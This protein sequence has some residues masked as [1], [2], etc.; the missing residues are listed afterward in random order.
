MVMEM[1]HVRRAGVKR[2][3]GAKPITAPPGLG[4]QTDG[5]TALE[6]RSFGGDFLTVLAKAAQV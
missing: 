1:V 2:P 3:A 4:S 6:R 5:Y